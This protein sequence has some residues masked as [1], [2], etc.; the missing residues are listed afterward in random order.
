[1]VNRSF[2]EHMVCSSFYIQ[3]SSPFSS[4]FRKIASNFPLEVMS[5][6]SLTS[7]VASTR[8]EPWTLGL[9]QPEMK[10]SSA[11]I[12]KTNSSRVFFLLTEVYP[13]P[14]IKVDSCLMFHLLLL[15][16][17]FLP[18]TMIRRNKRKSKSS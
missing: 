2:L 14:H 17:R 8:E 4:S 6:Q 12:K 1:M 11:L 5:H 15:E 9:Y 10:V 18:K 13:Q 7:K 16:V 3:V